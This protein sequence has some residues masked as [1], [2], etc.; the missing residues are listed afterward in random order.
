MI[1]TNDKMNSDQKKER[2]AKSKSIVAN[3][4]NNLTEITNPANLRKLL[5]EG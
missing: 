3:V 5:W 2:D 1:E 4:T